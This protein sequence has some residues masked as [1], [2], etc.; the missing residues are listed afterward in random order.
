[1]KSIRQ[2]YNSKLMRIDYEGDC[3]QALADH[4][5]LKAEL[6]PTIAGWIVIGIS[7]IIAMH[8]TLLGLFALILYLH[9]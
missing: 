8:G 5:G 6:V 2:W 7:L 9:S 4:L 1:M 3:G